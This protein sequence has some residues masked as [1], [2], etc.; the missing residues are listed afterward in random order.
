[1]AP[2]PGP[3]MMAPAPSPTTWPPVSDSPPR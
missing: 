3:T 2:G 1:V